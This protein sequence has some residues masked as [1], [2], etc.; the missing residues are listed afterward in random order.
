MLPTPTHIQVKKPQ[1]FKR[2]YEFWLK[3]QE[4]AVLDYGKVWYSEAIFRVRD[5]QWKFKTTGFWKR[6]IEVTAEQS[7]YIKLR[8]HTKW[9]YKMS[10]S[11]DNRNTWHFKGT[12]F[13]KRTWGWYDEKENMVIEIRSNYFSKKNRGEIILHQPITHDMLLLAAL[14]WYEVVAFEE[15]TSASAAA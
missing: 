3:E 13:W 1:I 10:V 15:H 4:L 11:L 8:I 2:H 7:P 5:H 12:G 6:F 14:G 9:A